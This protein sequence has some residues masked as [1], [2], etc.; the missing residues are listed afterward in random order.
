MQSVLFA[1]P[2]VGGS[3]CYNSALCCHT[4]SA[5]GILGFRST[6]LGKRRLESDWSRQWA[7]VT[8]SWGV[9]REPPQKWLPLQS[10]KEAT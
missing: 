10:R 1:A 8:T 9:T 5:L 4:H 2:M 3:S 7:A 6:H